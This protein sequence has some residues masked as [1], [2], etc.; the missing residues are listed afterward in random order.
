MTDLHPETVARIREIVE[1]RK[2]VYELKRDKRDLLAEDTLTEYERFDFGVEAMDNLLYEIEAN[3]TV[4][5][6]HESH[7]QKIAD[8]MCGGAP[9]DAY[10]VNATLY[11]TNRAPNGGTVMTFAPDKPLFV[12]KGGSVGAFHDG[13]GWHLVSTAKPETDQP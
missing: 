6:A 4:V 13:E 5:E 7:R 12:P 2:A 1:A 11:S 10:I 8:D 3:V 9:G